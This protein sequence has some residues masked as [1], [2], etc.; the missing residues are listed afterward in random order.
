MLNIAV[1]KDEKRMSSNSQLSDVRTELFIDGALRSTTEQL[2][3]MDPARG[4]LVGHCASATSD[5][6]KDAV[7]SAKRAFGSWSVLSATERAALLNGSTV[8]TDQ[9]A[10]EDAEILSRENGKVLAE[11]VRDTSMLDR[12]MKHVLQLA[13][14]V[15]ASKLLSAEGD[16]PT[17]TEVEYQPLGVVTIIVPFNWPVGILSTALSY[18][19]LAGNTVIVKPPP[20]APLAVTRVTTRMAAKLPAGVLNV[21]TGRDDVMGP[22]VSNVDVAKVCFT[23]S[24]AGGKKIMALAAE[25]LTRVTLELGGNDAAIV[26][27]DALLDEVSVTRLFTSMYASSGQICMNAKRIYV[28]QSRLDELVEKLSERLS[29]V[30]LGAGLNP[31][32]TMG[33]VHTKRQK[34]FVETLISDARAAGAR[35]LEF[36]E[37]PSEPDLKNGYFVRPTLVVTT[38][39]S[40]RVVT[41]EPFGPVVPIIPFEEEEQAIRYANDSWAGLGGSVW[42][43]NEERAE[44]LAHRLVCGYVWINDH[45]APRLD[46][47]APFG[48]MKQSGMGREQGIEGLRAFQDTRAIAHLDQGMLAK[49]TR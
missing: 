49:L 19:L 40:L 16:I 39:P 8:R 22:L 18:A 28:H 14:D 29:R 46:F 12:R 2:S 35:V 1:Q 25:N 21:V 5:D 36:G 42:S 24:V 33:P 7:A 37:I 10:A 38:D 20:S 47:R 32:T 43:A 15:E 26:L 48:G 34:E 17:N 44:R 23:G 27:D 6:V 13:E 11:C 45:G 31:A 3:V 30:V 9:E 41:E 4:T